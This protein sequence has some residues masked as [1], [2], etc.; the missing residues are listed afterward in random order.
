[1]SVVAM[2]SQC[3]KAIM[4]HLVDKS[5]FLLSD[6]KTHCKSLQYFQMSSRSLRTVIFPALRLPSRKF[7][8]VVNTNLA[9]RWTLYFARWCTGPP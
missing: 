5:D 8:P 2:E 4:V 3:M 7:Q 6:H 9:K 1:M